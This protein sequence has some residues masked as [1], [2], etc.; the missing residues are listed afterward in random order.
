M[1]PV[2]PVELT[3]EQQ[4]N[5]LKHLGTISFLNKAGET[6]RSRREKYFETL[7]TLQEQNG[8]RTDGVSK[9]CD[10]NVIING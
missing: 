3:P 9:V 5:F 10:S 8:Q 2:K 4:E 6:M 1:D 7:K